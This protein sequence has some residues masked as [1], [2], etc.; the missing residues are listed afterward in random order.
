MRIASVLIVAVALT[1]CSMQ[2]PVKAEFNGAELFKC[3]AASISKLGPGSGGF[4]FNCPD[5]ASLYVIYDTSIAKDGSVISVDVQAPTGENRTF[6]PAVHSSVRGQE[7]CPS[8]KALQRKT[9]E[10]PIPTNLWGKPNN[11]RYDLAMA[12]PCGTLTIT[13]GGE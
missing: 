10:A 6:L 2:T 11:G 1:A 7:D 13:L 12:K 8:A 3:N 9:G 5:R 4:R